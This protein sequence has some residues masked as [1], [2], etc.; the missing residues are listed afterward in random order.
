MSVE[1]IEKLQ[2]IRGML[3]GR[4]ICGTAAPLIWKGERNM[5]ILKKVYEIIDDS[6]E[7]I[8]SML[9][10]LISIPSVSVRTQGDKP[11]GEE[12]D[13]CF[14][15]MLQMATQ[16]GFEIFNADNYGGHI[17]YKG[18]GEETVGILGH[19]DVVPEGRDWDFAPYGGIISDGRIYGRGAIDDK[20]PVVAVF[21]AMKALKSVG[22]KPEKNI[23]LILGLDEETDWEGMEYYF[24]KMRKPDFG[25][26]PDGDFPAIHGEKGII[27]FDIADKFGK[28]Q[29]KG[30]ELRSVKGGNAANMVADYA[31]AILLSEDKSDYEKIKEMLAELRKQKG[32]KVTQKQIGKSLEIVVQGVSAHGAK[33]ELGVNAVSVMMDI[34]GH[35]NFAN[36]DMNSFI[37]FYNTHIGF[38]TDGS[39]MGC[40]LSDEASGS[41]IF[42]VGMIDLSSKSVNLTVNIRYPVT[43]DEDNVYA[44]MMPVINRY[45]MGVVKGEHKAPVYMPSDSP[46]I[47]TLMKVY[48]E[49]TGD[50][51]T[52]PLV[53]GGGTYARAADNIV[54]F[55]ACMPG[56]EEMAHQKNEYIRIDNLILITKIYAQAI[57]ELA[58][59]ETHN[60]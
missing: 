2:S 3:Y 32:Y 36:D 60:D 41:L 13:R 50:M 35:I 31:R 27:I 52:K 22:F 16:S 19:I 58:K 9:Q 17:E 7:E 5:T 42:N 29:T 54:A 57:Y 8:I 34:L 33:P 56:E 10:Q 39:S 51:D 40:G 53:I 43:F 11:F 37:D 4:D 38:E 44:A 45:N 28:S 48:R 15:F 47:T 18:I 1:Q 26:S 21:C 6:K 30:I 49:Q 55:G 59:G 23:R 20:G 12:V 25:F 14:Q 24:T 46:L